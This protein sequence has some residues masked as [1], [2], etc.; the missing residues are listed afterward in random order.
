ME[1]HCLTSRLRADAIRSIALCLMLGAAPLAQA[2]APLQA[3]AVP[4][5]LA[6]WV[7][8]VLDGAVDPA[9]PFIVASGTRECAWAG[10]LALDVG[11]DGADFAV[12]AETWAPATL[13]LP[14]SEGRWPQDVQLDGAA[15]VVTPRGG[16]PEI[17][18]P[19]GRHHITGRFDWHGVPESLQVPPAY[20]LLALT[21]QGE[22]IDQ[23]QRAPGGQL[24]LQAPAAGAADAERDALRLQVYRRV[25]D[26]LPLQVETLLEFDVAGTQREVR[27]TGALLA[28]GVPMRLDSALPLRLDAD[29]SLRVQV[30]P[31]HWQVRLTTRQPA[32]VD[33]LARPAGDAQW[34]AEELWVF[35]ARPALRVVDVTGGTPVDP[36]Q[37]TL[38]G[39]WQSLPAFRL[40]AGEGLRFV[41]QRR[42]D[43]APAPDRLRL[44]RELWLDFD[45]GGYTVQDTITGTLTRGWRLDAGSALAPGRVLLNGAPQFI[46]EFDARQGVEV[47]RGALDLRADSRIVPADTLNAVGWAQDFDSVDATLHLP[48]G[49]RLW[50]ARGVDTVS[51]TWLQRWTLLDL[52][53]VFIVALAVA[54]LWSWP[55]GALSLVALVLCWHEPDAPRQIW[56]HVLAAVALVR[57]LPTGR[58]RSL[59]AG[60]RNA[61]LLV[62]GVLALDFVVG[63]VRIGLYPQLAQPYRIDR[64]EALMRD[65]PSPMAEEAL[66]SSEVLERAA[67]AAAPGRSMARGGALLAGKASARR[68]DVQASYDPLANIQTGPGLPGWHWQDAQLAWRG[69][70]TA[71]QP[72]DLVLLS[73]HVNLGLAIARVATLLALLALVLRA[74]FGAPRSGLGRASLLALL[75]GVT[76]GAQAADDHPDPDLLAE[77]K[78]RLLLAPDCV[79]ACASLPRLTAHLADGHLQLRLRLHVATTSGIPLPGQAEQ[80]L[81]EAVIVDGLT[82]NALQRDAQGGLQIALSPGVHD[83]VLDGRA[84]RRT[85]FQL[86]LPLPAQHARVD[87]AGWAVD[88]IDR[89]S[90]RA[91]QLIFTRQQQIGAPAAGEQS[92]ALPPFFTLERTLQLG[93]D[94]RVHNRLTRVT[95]PGVGVALDIPLLTGESV[96]SEQVDVAHDAVHLELDANTRVREW[97]SVLPKSERIELRAPATMRWTETWRADISPIWHAD[98]DGIPVVLHQDQAG[99]W[100]PTWRPWPGETVTLTLTRP[101]GVPGRTLTIDSSALTL[102]PG[103]R[104]TDASLDFTLRSSQGGQH[105]LALPAGA[106]LQ[107]VT[108]NDTAQPIRQEGR[109]VTLPVVPGEQ[110]VNLSWRS[111]AGIRTLRTTPAFSLGSDSVNAAQTIVVPGDRWVLFAGGPMLGPAVLFWGSLIVVLIAAL[112]LGRLRLAPVPTWQ[113]LLLGIGLTQSSIEEAVLVVGWLLALGLRARLPA[114]LPKWQFN[115]VQLA[116]AGLT[117]AAFACLFEAIRHGLLGQ[118]AM[119][120]AGNGSSAAELRWFVD[121]AGPDWPRAWVLS[122]SIWFYRALMLA[123]ALWL[124]FALL[125]WLRWGWQHF[126]RDGV[127][128]RITL[129]TRKPAVAEG[130]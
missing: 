100:L 110:R 130:G 67:D 128:R 109:S 85:S 95:P 98:L 75:L 12:D 11:N 115:L 62:L 127:W 97:T 105:A 49:W 83:V 15:A 107:A 5:P 126:S 23:P 36:R 78:R 72:L 122:V 125:G 91:T 52:F 50:S 71:S 53:I 66:V 111:T 82:S 92:P 77:L 106:V 7:P 104:A 55:L 3:A 34:P 44:N 17:S 112:A 89:D 118:P 70:V 43:P 68:Y 24:W 103:Q 108:V 119:Q 123:W 2:A 76:G 117:L 42:G 51:D 65:A 88:G 124:A 63:Q 74:V 96:T 81:P 59:V 116:L 61:A 29:G 37:T 48:P 45:G 46:T 54:R 90:G 18:L 19:T 93:L 32:P 47:R 9:C 22:P 80:W 102:T 25:K 33:A 60:Y 40:A 16:V 56:L 8:W 73:P 10:H 14:G 58:L 129:F 113:W 31:G 30:R 13:A 99:Q 57:V 94:W 69:P 1:L 41:Q 35:D 39:E 28:D 21:R 79:P 27:F 64:A 26:E 86:S 101:A 121:R 4:A 38:P 84:P 120:I 114:D 87:A 20:G 6:P